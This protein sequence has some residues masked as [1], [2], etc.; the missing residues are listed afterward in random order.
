MAATQPLPGSVA[1]LPRDVQRLT[2]T[3]QAAPI[4]YADSIPYDALA[5]HVHAQIAMC[6]SEHGRPILQYQEFALG[7]E[8]TET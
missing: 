5:M 4:Q 1:A 2:Y 3:T 6:R 7:A 8:W